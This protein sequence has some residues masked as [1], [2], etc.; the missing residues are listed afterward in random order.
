MKAW[1]DH[2]RLYVKEAP[3]CLWFLGALFILVGLPFVYGSLG[4]FV[5]K[6]E[7]PFIAR[8]LGTVLGLVAIGTGIWIIFRAP[9]TI[10]VADSISGTITL[11]RRGIFR[12]T[13][14]V[15]PLSEIGKFV[16]IEETDSEGDPIW[17]LGVEFVNGRTEAVSSLQSH[18]E[19]YKRSFVFEGNQY[20]GKAL[21]GFT[22]ED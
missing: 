10:I 7:V 13:K 11:S 14:E 4:G 5:N 16:L 8:V 1:E 15:Y 9:V 6:D 20:L 3:G 17:S 18:S 19:A 21:P 12:W 22:D 2:G